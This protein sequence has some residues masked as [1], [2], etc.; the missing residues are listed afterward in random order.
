MTFVWIDASVSDNSDLFSF[1]P[2][3]TLAGRR[4]DHLCMHNIE[5][6]T[7]PGNLYNEQVPTSTA[8]SSDLRYSYLQ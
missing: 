6:P 8:K 2:E 7:L 1:L 3:E 4:S 5:P